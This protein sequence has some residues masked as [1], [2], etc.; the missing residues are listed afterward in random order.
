MTEVGRLWVETL[1]PLRVYVGERE[2]PLGPPK[3]QAVFAVLAL[4]NNTLVTRGD[5]IDHLWGSAPPATA[6]GSIHT[7]VSGLRRALGEAEASLTSSATGYGLRLAPDQLDIRVVERLASRAPTA[8]EHRP[9]AELSAYDEALAHWRPGSALAGVPGPFAE[10]FRAWA[11]DLS[12][13]LVRERAELLLALDRPVGLADELRTHVAA[14]PYDERL[15][16]LLITALCRSGRTA[17]ALAQYQDL[18]R[19]LAED[20]GIAPSAELRELNSAILTGNGR[21]TGAPEPTPVPAPALAAVPAPA[22]APATPAPV[23]RPAQLP[24]GV[25]AFVGRADAIGQVLAA[26]RGGQESSG[27]Q[28]TPAIMMVAGVGGVGKT[29]L[30]VHCAH[31]L[32]DEY[33]D[34]QL[35]LDLCGFAPRQQAR[36]SADGLHHLLTSLNVTDIPP[37]HGQRA[38]L[39][40]SIVRDKRM[41]IVLDNAD[42]AEQVEELLPGSGPSFTLVTSRNRLS[43]LAVRYSARRVVLGP[44]THPESLELLSAA[45]GPARV[46]AEESAARRLAELCDRL[47]LALRIAAEQVTAGSAARIAD[48][49]AELEDVRHRLDGLEIPDDELSSVRGVLSWSYARLDAGSARAFRTLGLLPRTPVRAEA[50]AALLDLSVPETVATLRNLAAHH[51][52][53]AADGGFRMHELTRL[54][55]GELSGEGESASWRR[56]T[57]ARLL[58]WHITALTLPPGDPAA[59]R[60]QA[61]DDVAPLV[62]TA[63]RIGCH[64]EAAHLVGLL[65]EHC[66]GSGRPRDWV[67]LLQLGLRSADLARDQD[68]RAGLLRQ[69]SRACSRLGQDGLDQVDATLGLLRNA[70]ATGSSAGDRRL[71]GLALF[72]LAKVRAVSGSRPAH[73]RELALDALARLEGVGATEA[74]EVTAFLRAPDAARSASAD[75]GREGRRVGAG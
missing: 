22:G 2:I 19:V 7:Y 26:A 31:R 44:L 54:Y 45:I 52:V 32:M 74:A 47:P 49:A 75:P 72:G 27:G 43:R 61:W 4:S 12:L 33:P 67:G 41:L 48:L 40:R 46:A 24:H 23:V 58:H 51:L 39:W 38:A 60:A 13:R 50:A 17:D 36:S 57:L 18:R 14:H 11:A 62:Q 42:S 34:G 37:D 65:F 30:A 64:A 9:L 10:G 1:G 21:G 28:P 8:P 53:E 59:W 69:L 25:G 35:Y 29:A 20:L 56:Q 16:A 15:R 66:Y 6:A 73:V 71:E 63:Q 5:L 70:L 55:A 68:S 3:Q